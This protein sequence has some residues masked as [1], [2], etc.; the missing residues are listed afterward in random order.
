M[1]AGHLLHWQV[2]AAMSFV[3]IFGTSLL[4]SLGTAH[5]YIVDFGY[6][7]PI[8]GK[9]FSVYDQFPEGT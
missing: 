8:T 9:D 6:L 3:T 5:V 7:Y 1:K 2:S 4:R